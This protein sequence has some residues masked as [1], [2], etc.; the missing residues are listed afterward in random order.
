MPERKVKIGVAMTVSAFVEVTVDDDN[1][2]VKVHMVD[3]ILADPKYVVGTNHT[4]ASGEIRLLENEVM[5]R[6][7]ETLANRFFAEVDGPGDKKP[8][9]IKTVANA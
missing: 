6:V 1:E 5:G 9:E 3:P 4:F 7:T 8:E 2:I